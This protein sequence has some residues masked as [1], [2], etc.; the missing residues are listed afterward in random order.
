MR[1]GRKTTTWTKETAPK[2][3]KGRKARKTIIKEA[4]GLTGWEKLKS[5]LENDGAEKMMETMSKMSGRDF[6]TAYNQM[7]DYIRPKLT[8]ATHVGDPQNPLELKS[9]IDLSK[10]T[11]EQQVALYNAMT[12]GAQTE[13]KG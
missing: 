11:P 12:N 1:G 7:A 5:Y 8:R 10:L 2:P 13:S 6:A 9:G 3:K 4:L